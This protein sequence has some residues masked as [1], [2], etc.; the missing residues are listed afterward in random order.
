[1]PSIQEMLKS[2]MTLAQAKEAYKLS[3]GTNSTETEES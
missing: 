1:M 2:G 3:R